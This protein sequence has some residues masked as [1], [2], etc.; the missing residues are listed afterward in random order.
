M[1]N[2]LLRAVSASFLAAIL[3]LG[4]S[5]MISDAAAHAPAPSQVVMLSCDMDPNGAIV[6]SMSSSS[7]GAPIVLIGSS[8]SQALTDV[9]TAGF[10]L[11]MSAFNG[12]Y[13]FVLE[14]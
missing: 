5:M 9:L 2:I 13:A 6:T 11:V 4:S 12:R 3:M 14:K 10:K 8:C 1:K 7:A